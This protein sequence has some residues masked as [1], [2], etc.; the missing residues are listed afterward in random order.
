MTQMLRT[1]IL[2][3]NTDHPSSEAIQK[4]TPGLGLGPRRGPKERKAFRGL[5]NRLPGSKPRSCP[6]GVFAFHGRDCVIGGTILLAAPWN[7]VQ[8]SCGP[9]R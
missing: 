4:S 7:V 9:S 2:P 5:I 8:Y 3:T 1:Q 6:R